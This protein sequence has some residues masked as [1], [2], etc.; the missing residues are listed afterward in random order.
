MPTDL[1]GRSASLAVAADSEE[2]QALR[3][4]VFVEEQ[5]VPVGLERDELDDVAA[6][7]VV[8]DAGGAVVGTGRMVVQAAGLARVGRM[9]V[10]P[11]SRGQGVGAALLGV[12]EAAAA[13]TGC[14]RVEVHAQVHAAGFYRWAGYSVVGETFEEAGITHVAMVKD[15]S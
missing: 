3:H 7:A 6:H 12:L 5:G 2:L 11:E 13:G 10:A 9:A 4:R 8:R 1:T 15:L 14:R